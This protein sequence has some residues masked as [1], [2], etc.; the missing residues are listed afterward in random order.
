MTD[1]TV[2]PSDTEGSKMVEVILYMPS[3]PSDE[4]QDTEYVSIGANP[5]ALRLE[6][7]PTIDW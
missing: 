4:Y 7:G 1:S 6:Q 5:L 2:R 3:A